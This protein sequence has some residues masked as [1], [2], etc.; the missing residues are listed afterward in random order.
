MMEDAYSEVERNPATLKIIDW[1]PMKFSALLVIAIVIVS[2]PVQAATSSKDQKFTGTYE[3]IICKGACS[4][5][6]R[7]NVFATAVVVFFDSVITASDRE[8]ID[9]FYNYDPSDV[10]ACYAVSRKMQAHSYVGINNKTGVAPWKL[11]GHTVQFDLFHSSDA[12]YVVEVNR[13]GD[14]LIGT[15]KSWGAGAGA[16]PSAYAPD[17]VLSRMFEPPPMSPSASAPTSSST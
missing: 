6:D 15:G 1:W 10:R 12:G 3:F 5:S 2:H 4:F 8:R 16:P 13:T 17:P 14:L 7:G 11:D 9:P